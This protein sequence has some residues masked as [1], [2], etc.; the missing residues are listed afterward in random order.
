MSQLEV[1]E[2]LS[3][4]TGSETHPPTPVLPQALV[5]KMIKLKTVVRLTI[6][7]G[8]MLT[9]RYVMATRATPPAHLIL[10]GTLFPTTEVEKR[11]AA[12]YYWQKGLSK[13]TWFTFSLV[14]R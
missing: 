8:Y 14:F 1:R 4:S 12:R 11:A 13:E 3:L 2:Q 5:N 9:P 10:F 7:M 6:I